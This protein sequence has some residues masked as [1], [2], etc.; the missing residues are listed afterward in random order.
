VGDVPNVLFCNGWIA[1]DDGRVFI[2]YASSDSRIHLA[3]SS[4]DRLV[5]HA[6]NSPPD[7]LRSSASLQQRITLIRRNLDLRGRDGGRNGS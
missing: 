5:D 4:I 2:Y 1:D 6:K 3:T 7:G